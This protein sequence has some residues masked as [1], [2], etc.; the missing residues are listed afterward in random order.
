MIESFTD[1]YFMKK[2]LEEA[3]LAYQE[4]EVPIGAVV[5]MGN[6]I[7]GRGHN[8]IERL[9]DVTAHAEILAITA[10]SAYLGSK[11]L[12]ECKIYVTLEPCVMCAYA[13]QSAQLPEMIFA[14]DDPKEGYRQFIPSVVHAQMLVKSGILAE[15]SSGLI[16]E[17]FN[18]KRQRK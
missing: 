6:T 18:N 4:D 13:I 15:K 10:A 16:L 2:A 12:K 17:F 1:E 9:N 3:A 5:V 14:A 7:I 11:Y 8:Q